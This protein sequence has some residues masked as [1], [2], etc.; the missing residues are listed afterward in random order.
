MANE[1][2]LDDKKETE[3]GQSKPAPNKWLARLAA[4]GLFIVAAIAGG[5]YYIHSQAYESTD[6]AFLEGSVVQVSPQVAGPVIRVHVQDNQHVNR[7]DLL[8]EIDPQDY[9]ARAAEARGRLADVS[10]RATGA[11]S[12]LEL[13]STVTKAVLTQATAAAE[14][15]REQLRIVQA[16]IQQ[17]AAAVKAAEAAVAQ[18]AAQLAA[19]QAEAERA[20][21]DAARYRAL[22]AKDEISQQ[23]LDRAETQFR[24][25]AA[26]KDAAQQAVEAAKARLEQARAAQAATEA[27]FRQ[28][29]SQ[30]T[31]AEGRVSEAQT[32]PQQVRTRQADVL[33]L[34]AQTE[35]VGA[36]VKQAELALSY[37]R[38]YAPESG[39]VTRKAVE[40]GNFVQ[41][42]Q[43]L[44]ALVLDRL[45]V[46]A[47]F[48]ETQL[49]RM[50]PGQP[51]SLKV[52]AYPQLRLRGRI[53]SIQSGTGARF[54]LLPA[55]NATGNYV[56]V[57]Q[58]VPVKIVLDGAPPAGYR[59]GPGMSVEPEVKVQ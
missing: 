44:M 16:R 18:A 37:T 42:G 59:L 54:S 49:A 3:T 19:S 41:P 9:E 24:A 51:V 29:E 21:A 57:I 38:I 52:D 48:K 39:Y 55:E 7:G 10:S 23:Q 5:A 32:G 13:T 20:A 17:D 35:Q 30:L 45:W 25:A 53:E 2:L 1:N 56:K 34:A 8:A 58:R 6:N 15:A 33:S 14:A 36:A 11:Q 31:Q 4:L 12:N 47:N 46:M 43:P 28:A 27:T 22:H 50:H 40:A 26:G